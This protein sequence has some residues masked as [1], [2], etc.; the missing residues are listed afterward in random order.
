MKK[1]LV[2]VDYQNDFV[3][4][5]LG[6][7]GAKNIEGFIVDKIEEY[8]KGGHDLFFT[9]DTHGENYMSTQEG[10]KLPVPHCILG[11]DGHHLYGE[12]RELE[13]QLC[14]SRYYVINKNAFPSLELGKLI[15]NK[16]YEVIEFVGLVSFICVLSNAI[17]AK[18]AAPEAEI[19][20]NRKGTA[21][22]DDKLHE[23]C[24]N[25]MDKA[26]QITVE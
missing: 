12:V 7:P 24:L 19:I 18:A 15:E 1:L 14:G 11:T 5:S 3:D 21:G 4:G 20:V 25:L 22:Y 23:D 2:V 10:R 6:F 9:L 26:L 16:G 17:I 8:T 13:K